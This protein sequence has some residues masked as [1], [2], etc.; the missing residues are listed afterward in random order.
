[1]EKLKN[2][3]L[4]DLEKILRPVGS[5]R[6]KSAYV[7]NI[8]TI[9]SNNYNGKVP[10]ERDLLILLPGVGRKTANVFLSEYYNKPAI[11][12]DT[13]VER[14]SKRLKLASK[15]DDVLSVEKKL[16][17]YFPKQEWTKRH[18]QILLFGRYYCKA[19]KP[20]CAECKLSDICK[21]KEHIKKEFIEFLFI[22]D[23]VMGN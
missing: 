7:K 22:M 21:E 18:L 19:I 23:F 4:E 2:A 12:V 8:A 17:K 11:A 15:N 14:V 13:H 1:M 10:A 20:N 6:K 16:M 5:F 9:L 3:P